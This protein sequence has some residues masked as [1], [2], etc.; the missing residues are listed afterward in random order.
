MD[1]VL[2]PTICSTV[3]T[4]TETSP[5]L[6]SVMHHTFTLTYDDLI[7]HMY[8]TVSRENTESYVVDLEERSELP[9]IDNQ[10]SACT[11]TLKTASTL[12][13][14]LFHGID[15]DRAMGYQ[16]HQDN[17]GE[18]VFELN[19]GSSP[20]F[21]GLRFPASDIPLPARKAYLRTVMRCIID[22][23]ANPRPMIGP[24]FP[25]SLSFLR[26]CAYPHVEYLSSMGVVSSMSLALNVS[27]NL[28]GLLAFHSY[29]QAVA[30]VVDLRVKCRL[31]TAVASS[32]IEHI[33]Q[34]S[35]DIL[36]N[37]LICLLSTCSE[38]KSLDVFLIENQTALLD[39]FR[40]HSIYLIHP[41]RSTVYVGEEGLG[42]GVEVFKHDSIHDIHRGELHDPTRSFVTVGVNES[43]FV[44]TRLANTRDIHW[45]GDPHKTGMRPR[46]SFETYI[47]TA[48]TTPPEFSRAEMNLFELFVTRMKLQAQSMRA[49]QLQRLVTGYRDRD[50]STDTSKDFEMF[51]HMSHER[52]T[53]LHTLT[54]I[55]DIINT[56]GCDEATISEYSGIGIKVS[57][58]MTTTLDSF[59]D[60]M[61]TTH[62][63][64]VQLS[65]ISLQSFVET[66]IC[67][68]QVFASRNDVQFTLSY[69]CEN[70]VIA[71]IDTKKFGR[72]VNNVC[73]NAIK[74]S[75][76]KTIDFRV[77][78]DNDVSQVYK[79]RGDTSSKYDAAHMA[80]EKDAVR[81]SNVPVTQ[82]WIVLQVTDTGSGILSRD[83]STIF[84]PFCQSERC[85]QD[86]PGNG[87]RPPYMSKGR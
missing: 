79:V 34:R 57:T 83:I 29:S 63:K 27:G 26:G 59:L 8:V 81:Q 78:I 44:F 62:E 76:N 40:C 47:Q 11:T 65:K 60:V 53:P 39:I 35:A 87:T 25:T 19:R 85:Q 22:V 15:Y 74:F 61:K 68:L 10:I 50:G 13:K 45:A 58:D 30:P 17:S 82:K 54:G 3:T 52:R 46:E 72:I 2:H 5:A 43:R 16:L 20:S 33:E 14:E 36:E 77:T 4:S 24:N 6:G 41:S 28:W 18:V 48:Q 23:R 70:S 75:Q 86:L 56:S 51:S 69:E 80:T 64:K 49:R 12:C 55:L 66:E 71:R 73:G 37:K 1:D 32:H 7:L 9:Y 31:L 67:G 21:Y 42:R 38:M 84:S